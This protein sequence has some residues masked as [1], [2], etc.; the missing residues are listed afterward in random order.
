MVGV[1][2]GFPRTATDGGCGYGRARAG[3][4][5]AG[6]AFPG[7]RPLRGRFPPGAGGRGRGGCGD[8]WDG[9]PGQCDARGVG[10]AGARIARTFADG[11]RPR[12]PV[13]D[14]SVLLVSELFG[15]NVRGR[16]QPGPGSLTGAALRCRNWSCWPGM[17]EVGRAWVAG[18][19]CQRD[20]SRSAPIFP[21]RAEDSRWNL[22][23]PGD[24]SVR[25]RPGHRAARQHLADVT[26]AQPRHQPAATPPALPTTAR[27]DHRRHWPHAGINPA[28][29]HPILPNSGRCDSHIYALAWMPLRPQRSSVQPFVQRGARR[30]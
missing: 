24:P 11:A 26:H 29:T 28:P 10:G 25:P 18:Q 5:G 3:G 9:G 22:P 6:R 13:R 16:A 4:L 12:P 14:A 30:T 21:I 7:V 19:A 17:R 2:V 8:G 23:P 27:A 1:T 15:N 20:P